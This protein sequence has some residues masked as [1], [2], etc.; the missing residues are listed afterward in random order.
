MWG[1]SSEGCILGNNFGRWH[2]L[3]TYCQMNRIKTIKATC[4]VGV[5]HKFAS[6]SYWSS[7]PFTEAPALNAVL[8]TASGMWGDRWTL[9][10]R[11]SVLKAD[12][13]SPFSPTC[14]HPLVAE[15]LW[16]CSLGFYSG[17]T[18]AEIQRLYLSSHSYIT[19]MGLL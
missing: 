12:T 4:N 1:L 11:W 5:K 14:A 18:N 8:R 6:Q 16:F 10:T 19:C 17:P 9:S 13:E 7:S 15:E 3:I 2:K